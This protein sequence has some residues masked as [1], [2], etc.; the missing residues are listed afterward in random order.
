MCWG[1]VGQLCLLRGWGWGGNSGPLPGPVALSLDDDLVGV[2]SEAIEG[3]LGEDRVIKEG[4]PLVDTAVRCDDGGA[5]SMALDDDLI[6]VAGLL[7]IESA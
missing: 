7:C 1:R 4:D 5:A 2:V 3:T 6:E